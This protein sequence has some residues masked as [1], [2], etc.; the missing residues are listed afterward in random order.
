MGNRTHVESLLLL[1][2]SYDLRCFVLTCL[3]LLR[4]RKGLGPP[5][6]PPPPPTAP[7]D[8]HCGRKGYAGAPPGLCVMQRG[9]NRHHA[10]PNPH[11]DYDTLVPEQPP[12]TRGDGGAPWGSEGT[13][14]HH[15]HPH[16][17]G[18][19][20]V[21]P[22]LPRPRRDRDAPWGIVGTRRCPLPTQRRLHPSPS[23]PA[24]AADG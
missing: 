12:G 7:G 1:P 19:T 21:P 5:P 4:V 18:C 3:L 22:V 14:H 10:S 17:G 11:R 8:P 13:R 2:R 15:H 9:A 23:G 6:P 24:W 20:R 16:S